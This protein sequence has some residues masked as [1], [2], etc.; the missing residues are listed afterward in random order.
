MNRPPDKIR[1]IRPDGLLERD[2][3]V[4]YPISSPIRNRTVP[5]SVT[6]P[7]VPM[8][9]EQTVP[10]AAFLK[11]KGQMREYRTRCAAAEARVQALQTTLAELLRGMNHGKGGK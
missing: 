4:P 11:L 5:V 1:E 8:S 10:L 7:W 9:L 6:V 3:T 2:R